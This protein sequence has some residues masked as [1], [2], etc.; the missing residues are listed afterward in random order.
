MNNFSPHI[1]AYQQ[2]WQEQFLKIFTHFFQERFNQLQHGLAFTPRLSDIVVKLPEFNSLNTEQENDCRELSRSYTAP[3][4]MEFRLNKFGKV[5]EFK[6]GD[7]PK[8]T[9]RGSYIINGKERMIIAQLIKSSGINFGKEDE[10]TIFAEIRPLQGTWLRLTIC[11]DE[12]KER[13]YNL[14]QVTL[15]RKEKVFLPTLL[16]GLNCS[17]REIT[18]LFEGKKQIFAEKLAEKEHLIKASDNIHLLNIASICH[19][20]KLNIYDAEKKRLE[21]THLLELVSKQLLN[22]NHVGEIGRWQINRRLNKIIGLTLPSLKTPYLTKEDLLGAIGYLMELALKTDGF[23]Y[24]DQYCLSNKQVRLIDSLLEQAV[25]EVFKKIWVTFKT[26]LEKLLHNGNVDETQFYR[27]FVQAVNTGN[28]DSNTGQLDRKFSLAIKEIFTLSPLSRLVPQDNS[29]AAAATAR[30]I[31]Y[32]GGPALGRMLSH[33]WPDGISKAGGQAKTLR[34]LHWSHY[35]R[36]CP[37]DTPQGESIG[38]TLSL[39]PY[40]K[41]NELGMLI[42]P[43]RKVIQEADGIRISDTI[44]YLSPD[45]E[46]SLPGWIAYADQLVTSTHSVHWRNEYVLA[47]R[48]AAELEKVSAKEISHIDA[49]AKQPFS[50]AALLIPFLAHDDANRALMACNAMRQALPLVNPEPPLVKTGYEVVLPQLS[51]CS[52]S[53]T[54][55]N[56]LAFGQNLLVAFVPW[57]GLNFEDAIAIS[58]T[59][60]E[61]LTH[62]EFRELQPIKVYWLNGE[63]DLKTQEITKITSTFDMPNYLDEEGVVKL[64]TYIKEGDILISNIKFKEALNYKSN[65]ADKGYT[66]K[67]KRGIEGKVIKIVELYSD[68]IIERFLDSKDQISTVARSL[69]AENR[70]LNENLGA[71]FKLFKFTLQR[72]RPIKIGDKLTNRHGGKGV[73]SAILADEEMPY[74]YDSTS[75]HDCHSKGTHRHVEILTN[76]LGVISRLNLG[77]VYEAHASWLAREKGGCLDN[78]ITL[79]TIK[80]AL[81]NNSTVKDGKAVLYDPTSRHEQLDNPITVGYC[82]FIKLE[83]LAEDKAHA[84]SK[85]IA[86]YSMVTQQPLKGKKRVGGQRLGEMEVWA[87]EAYNTWD[88]LQE[89]LT[90]KSDD[91]VGRKELW[92]AQR[93]INEKENAFPLPKVPEIVKVLIIYL[94]GMGLELDIYNK[95]GKNLDL[96]SSPSPVRPADIDK[97][98]LRIAEPAEILKWSYGNLIQEIKENP[99]SVADSLTSQRIFGLKN[100]YICECFKKGLLETSSQLLVSIREIVAQSSNESSVVNVLAP[101]KALPICPKCKLSLGTSSLRRERMGHIEL[102]CPVL[103]V[104]F[105]KKVAVLLDISEEGLKSLLKN[106]PRIFFDTKEKSLDFTIILLKCSKEFVKRYAEPLE[107]LSPKVIKKCLAEDTFRELIGR[108]SHEQIRSFYTK[109]LESLSGV[110]VLTD[111]LTFYT[112]DEMASLLEKLQDSLVSL[113]KRKGDNDKENKYEAKIRQLRQRMGVVQSFLISNTEPQSLLLKYIPV[114]PPDLRPIFIDDKGIPQRGDLD[115]LY[116]EIIKQNIKIKDLPEGSKLQAGK[117]Y[118][119]WAIACLIDN[120]CFKPMATNSRG[121]RR[122]SFVDYFR[123][124]QG[125]L[126]A[127]M[128]GKRVDYSARG[129][130]VPDPALS[131]NDCSLPYSIAVE[132]FRPALVQARALQKIEV[133]D[134]ED[135]KIDLSKIDR[136]IK[137]TLKNPEQRNA[138]LANFVSLLHKYPILLNRQPTLHRMGIQAFYPKINQEYVIALHPLVTAGYNADF[139]GDTIAIYRPVSPIAKRDAENLLAIRNILSPANGNITLHLG[140][141]IALGIYYWTLQEG[142]DKLEQLLLG[143]VT[144]QDSHIVG[145]AKKRLS[146]LIKIAYLNSI[147][148]LKNN[149]VDMVDKFMRQAFNWATRAGV[150]FS[151]L[152]LPDISKEKEQLLKSNCSDRNDEQLVEKM[153]QLAM[154][155]LHKDR[156]LQLIVKSGAKGSADIVNQ[157]IGMRGIVESSSNVKSLIGSSLKEGMNI[158]EYFVS[159]YQARQSLIEKSM[160]PAEAGYLSRKLIDVA[161]AIS[162]NIKDCWQENDQQRPS[163]LKISKEQK[164]WLY[165]RTLAKDVWDGENVFRANTVLDLVAAAKLA[166][167]MEENSIEVEIRSPITCKSKRGICQQCYG[168]DLSIGQLPEITAR[169]GI[170][171]A[172]SIG[173]PGTQLAMRAF[174]AGGFNKEQVPIQL[175]NKFFDCKLIS[176]PSLDKNYRIEEDPVFLLQ[177]VKIIKSVYTNHVQI[178]AKHFEIIIRQMIDFVEIT[179]TGRSYFYLGQLVSKA[180]FSDE[181]SRLK[182]VNCPSNEFPVPQQV[183]ISI[184]EAALSSPSW[185]SASSFEQGPSILA[186]AAILKRIDPLLGLKENIILGRKP[187]K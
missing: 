59:A 55:N 44:E 69:L 97:V 164:D 30:R 17:N 167:Q 177:L 163:G 26:R 129:V 65:K 12:A 48:G 4:L 34:G 82:Y 39:T 103:N 175:A 151:I 64:G 46:E 182:A 90:V 60:A 160:G 154:S 27:C 15:R 38:M 42:A 134:R 9:S 35:G 32:F 87:L 2:F 117:K 67:V 73:I 78:E 31:T 127:N 21:D 166:N 115:N 70:N 16:K 29:I 176:L 128:L 85:E 171:A 104:L 165:G 101:K 24:D 161:H 162:I 94:R 146:E 159:A 118:L 45:Q 83:H 20:L 57:K 135:E 43:Y 169:V 174:H 148:S 8:I 180:D 77:Q 76:P 170:I 50:I 119:Q 49:F 186:D 108:H 71:T 145:V 105:F 110:D 179:A 185:L 147:S 53:E 37:V 173:E 130:I 120:G 111:L 72:I 142:S 88:L 143:T 6:L 155:N 144:S 79:E 158:G 168:Y 156:S 92:Q 109:A 81:E 137:A 13:I 74:F 14:I 112:K 95:S 133:M 116:E 131:L 75:T 52:Y 54:V 99:C 121:Q 19:T 187:A 183:I 152:D 10:S 126:R 132:L 123:G 86:A 96:F 3:L 18:A 113:I 25:K 124:K 122:K 23:T 149:F 141:D 100:D 61:K 93:S 136:F 36:I 7:I 47:H 125:L 150:T 56:E 63:E 138:I 102:H 80:A 40:V 84:R 107:G 98:R 62:I 106:E 68:K 1:N 184:G 140:L 41:V 66:A 5:Y 172:Q 91:K 28:K 11:Q 58:K 139:D 153:K 89:M 181:L 22:E 33:Y 157:M 114:I 51:K 178:D